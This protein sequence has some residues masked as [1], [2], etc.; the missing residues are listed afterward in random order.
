MPAY[1]CDIDENGCLPSGWGPAR[2]FITVETLARSIGAL[3]FQPRDPT[4]VAALSSRV[5]V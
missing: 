4:G 3:K 2:V 1:L 5:A